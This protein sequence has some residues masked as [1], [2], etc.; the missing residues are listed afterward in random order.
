M[1]KEYIIPIIK[2]ETIGT[3]ELLVDSGVTGDGVTNVDY[4]GIDVEGTKDP[5]AKEYFFNVWDEE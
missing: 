5:S 4:G 1:K 2:V 3:E